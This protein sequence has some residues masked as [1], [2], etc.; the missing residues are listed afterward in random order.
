M[1]DDLLKALGAAGRDERTAADKA[2]ED[3]PPL[4]AAARERLVDDALAALGGDAPTAVTPPE[5][6]SP[7]PTTSRAPSSSTRP[8]ALVPA[9]PRRLRPLV[10]AP[11]AA[12][13]AVLLYLFAFAGH[14]GSSALPSYDLAVQGG[15]SEWRSDDPKAMARERVTVRADG[16]VELTLRPA[17]PVALPLEARAF[18]TREGVEEAR[19]EPKLLPV[20]VSG[21]GVARVFGRAS[22]L[23]ATPPVGTS[24]RWTILVVVGPRGDV[25]TTIA[26]ARASRDVRRSEVVV[27]VTN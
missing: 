27:V 13:A 11:L 4:D 7:T 2:A 6:A 21:Q 16:T 8:D 26:G 3:A 9:P 10:F 24:E 17:T 14:R 5:T 23:L 22:D 12:A 25:P 1:T 15:Q 18:A 19:L 20:E